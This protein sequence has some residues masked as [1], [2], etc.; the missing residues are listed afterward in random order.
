MLER[1]HHLGIAVRDLEA[2]IAFYRETFGVTEWERISMPERSMD[3]A[4]C[5]LG[6]TLLELITP[7]SEQAAFAR[8]LAERGEG[9]HHVAYEVSDLEAALRELESRGLRLVDQ[10]GRPGIHNTTVAFLHPKA[11][12]GTLVELVEPAH[13]EQT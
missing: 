11:T 4:V 8:F 9:L 13:P 3:V 5:K 2:T 6:D 7:T 10:H 12:F 1:V